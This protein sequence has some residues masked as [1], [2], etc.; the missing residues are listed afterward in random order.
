MEIQNINTETIFDK[1]RLILDKIFP[2][3]NERMQ[4]TIRNKLFRLM[5]IEVR[6]FFYE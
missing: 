3:Y 4:L 2:Y 6:S 5:S 1:Y